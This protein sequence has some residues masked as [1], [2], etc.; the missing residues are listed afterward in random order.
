[1]YYNAGVVA[2]DSKVVGLASVLKNLDRQ[3]AKF[4]R[5]IL[6]H[7]YIHTYILWYK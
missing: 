1:M 3:Y 4:S 6:H 5:G 7:T 2:V